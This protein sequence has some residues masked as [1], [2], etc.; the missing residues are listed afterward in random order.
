MSRLASAI[1]AKD[2]VRARIQCNNRVIPGDR[3]GISLDEQN[4]LS[5]ARQASRQRLE[6]IKKSKLHPVLGHCNALDLVRYGEYVLGE[7]IGNCLEMTCAVAWYLNQQGLFFY[8]PAYYPDGPPGTPK[9]DHIFMTLGQITD[10][11][12]KFPD[13]FANWSEQ[14]VICDAWAD[15]ACPAQEYPAQWQARMGEWD[16]QHYLIAN[17][18]PT[19]TMW[20]NLVTYPK[21]SY[22][23]G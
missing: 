6:A 11:E 23:S 3:L 13:N 8:E 22:F 19:H 9:R 17:L 16:Q 2:Y 15:I 12:G 10:A 18:Q 20:L 1:A 4:E 21:R 5:L 14:A 7:G